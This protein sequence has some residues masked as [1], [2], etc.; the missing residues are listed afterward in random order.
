MVDNFSEN[1]LASCTL[2]ANRFYSYPTS[3]QDRIFHNGNLPCSGIN[4]KH[5]DDSSWKKF[6]LSLF[7]FSLSEKFLCFLGRVMRYTSFFL[8]L[9][10]FES[11]IRAALAPTGSFCLPLKLLSGLFRLLDRLAKELSSLFDWYSILAFIAALP[12]LFNTL[13]SSSHDFQTKTISEAWVS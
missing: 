12:V 7:P 11:S 1:M 10:S 8:S 2:Q 6:S 9:A 3:S 4:R 13:N 5:V